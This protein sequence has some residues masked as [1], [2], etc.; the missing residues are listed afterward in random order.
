MSVRKVLQNFLEHVKKLEA[1]EE[2]GGK[3]N[4][5]REFQVNILQVSPVTFVGLN[6]RKITI[7]YVVTEVL[8]RKTM[9][10]TDKYAFLTF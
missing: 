1:A 2:E 8:K 6:V 9:K 4:F 10:A 5:S 7:V 3:G